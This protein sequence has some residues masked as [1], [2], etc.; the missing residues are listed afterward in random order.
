MP[1]WPKVPLPL[2][3][4]ILRHDSKLMSQFPAGLGFLMLFYGCVLMV[5][6]ACLILSPI[7]TFRTLS[8]GKPLPQIMQN[9]WITL[10]YRM[11]GA[12]PV[13]VVLRVILKSLQP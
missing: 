2:P 12:L 7:G 13:V 5:F 3:S 9:R 10:I 11:V 4:S 8:F 1:N 6:G